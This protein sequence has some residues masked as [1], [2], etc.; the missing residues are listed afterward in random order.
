VSRS[1]DTV[2]VQSGSVSVLTNR[3]PAKPDSTVGT[4]GTGTTTGVVAGDIILMSGAT[5]PEYNV[6]Q[7]VTQVADS[8]SC[9]PTDPKDTATKCAAANA[10]ATTR[11]RLRSRIAGAPASPATGTPVYR[12]YTASTTSDY[13]IPSVIY[14]I[15]RRP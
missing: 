6:W 3:S 15:D 5:Q 8:L 4:T 1:N 13:T 11:F 9:A 14:L 12:I 7:A 2:T 10:V